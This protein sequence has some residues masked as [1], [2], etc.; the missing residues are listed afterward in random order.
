MKNIFK[1]LLI[2]FILSVISS[3]MDENVSPLTDP[4]MVYGENASLSPEKTNGKLGKSPKVTGTVQILWNGGGKK[5]DNGNSPE[6]M[7]AFAGFEGFEGT[8]KREVK[9]SFIY[10]VLTV[11]SML[12]RE[13]IAKLTGVF[14]DQFQDKVWM[15]GEVISD[16]KGCSGNGHG[17][18]DSGCQG[19]SCGGHDPGGHDGGCSGG[20]GDDHTDGG[21]SNPD[22]GD[23]DHT[24]G[25][26]SNPDHADSDHTDGGCTDTD[27]TDGGCTDTDHTDGGCTD[28]DHT[29]GGCT[30]TD[31][32]DGGCSG[33]DH[34]GGSPGDHGSGGDSGMGNPLKGK[35]C[36]VGQIIAIKCHDVVT[37]G[38][39][40]DGITWKWYSKEGSF[41]PNVYNISEWRHL[42]KKT[43]LEGNIQVHK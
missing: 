35:N 4:N 27:H 7:L 24:D 40:G 34:T 6:E 8:S 32:T 3:C 2:G 10:Q 22:H 14:I 26:C 13:V 38:I 30:D 17:G 29:D 28:T 37:P 43:I 5:M 1:T 39:D 9:G 18:H 33:S 16:T 15:V 36:R 31:H 11:D 25:G 19:G 42:C 21:C 23:A 20:D 41:V 12:H